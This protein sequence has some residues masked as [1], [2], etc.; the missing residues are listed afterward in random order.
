LSVEIQDTSNCPEVK[1]V[2][3]A[4]GSISI[5]QSRHSISGRDLN[6][7]QFRSD[8]QSTLTRPSSVKGPRR[9]RA[10]AADTST[11]SPITGR[12]SLKYT[13]ECTEHTTH[14]PSLDNFKP[15]TTF[16]RPSR[17][18]SS[19]DGMR[20]RGRCKR[21]VCPTRDGVRFEDEE[22]MGPNKCVPQYP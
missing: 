6:P 4:H 17:T 5:Y 21:T 12:C 13:G 14:S 22:D 11:P 15:M 3:L 8:E 2:P 7:I 18:A 19:C 10:R 9:A 16:I 1:F 20:E